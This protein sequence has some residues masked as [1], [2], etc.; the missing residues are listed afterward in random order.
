M[1][2]GTQVAFKVRSDCWILALLLNEADSVLS[3]GDPFCG[4]ESQG[5]LSRLKAR[6]ACWGTEV[7]HHSTMFLFSLAYAP[8]V[9]FLTVPPFHKVGIYLRNAGYYSSLGI[10]SPYV[11]WNLLLGTKIC[12]WSAP[13]LWL[14]VLIACLCL[15]FQRNNHK[16]WLQF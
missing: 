6:S 2:N 7:A 15:L 9:C 11:S 10:S 16:V 1:K 14:K 8:C 3:P 13:V 5:T 12:C 4:I